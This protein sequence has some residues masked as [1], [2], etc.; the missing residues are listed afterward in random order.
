MVVSV[1]MARTKEVHYTLSQ[2]ASKLGVCETTIQSYVEMGL[3]EKKPWRNTYE[4]IIDKIK[5]NY[6]HNLCGMNEHV[7]PITD[8]IC[9]M[10]KYFPVDN[11][12]DNTFCEFYDDLRSFITRIEREVKK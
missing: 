10:R 2:A 6:Y 4:Y 5:K 7:Q 11:M 8:F 3:I 9:L 1:D 12:G